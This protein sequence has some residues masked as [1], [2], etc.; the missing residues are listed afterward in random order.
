MKNGFTFLTC[1]L[2]TFCLNPL[3][4][5]AQVADTAKIRQEIDSLLTTA[6]QR[7]RANDLQVALLLAQEAGE[8]SKAYLGDKDP[9]YAASLH[10][11]ASIYK[12]LVEYSKAEELYLQAIALRAI[13]PGKEHPDY[14]ASLNNL[15]VLYIEN[16]NY[17]AA[18]PLL[19]EVKVIREKVLGNENSD[20]ATGLGNLA[21]LY[22]FKGAFIQAESLLLTAKSILGKGENKILPTYA[23]TLNNLASFYTSLGDYKKAEPLFLEAKAIQE[24]ILP[25]N[26]PDRANGLNNLGYLYLCKGDYAT[27]EPLLLE[28][29][30]IWEKG[31]GKDH[32]YYSSSLN[33][34]A[35][36]YMSNN[37][38]YGKAEPLSIEAA[39]IWEKR[40]GIENTT[41]AAHQNNLAYIYHAEGDDQKARSSFLRANKANQEILRKASTYLSEQEMLQYAELFKKQT[42]NLISFAQTNPSDSLTMA[43]Y[44]YVLFQKNALLDAAIA[45]EH[46]MLR[47]DTATQRIHA[48]W[49]TYRHRL[50]QQFVLSIEHRDTALMAILKSRVYYCEKEL[51]RRAPTFL[52]SCKLI[53]WEQ[54]R[55]HLQPGQIAI[56]FISYQYIPAKLAG[57]T[58]LY[59]ALVLRADDAAPIFVPLCAEKQLEMLIDT[60][61]KSNRAEIWESYIQ[62][63]YT[64]QSGNSS[65]YDLIWKPLE[66]YIAS[67]HPLRKEKIQIFFAPDGL[68]HRLSLQAIRNPMRKYMGEQYQLTQ[69]CSTRRLV[70]PAWYQP[71]NDSIALFGGIY[72]DKDSTRIPAPPA[73]RKV[74]GAPWED[75]PGSKVEVENIA[76][77]CQKHGFEVAMFTGYAATKEAVKSL[78]TNGNSS[79]RVLHI[80]THSFFSPDIKTEMPRTGMLSGQQQFSVDD[81]MRRAKLVLAG[82]NSARS[83]A[84]M[85]TDAEDGIL[86]AAEIETINFSNTELV[87]L[88]A[89]NT[90]LGDIAGNEGVYG[91]QR[92]FKV[93][94]SKYLIMS[95]WSVPDGATHKLMDA[96]YTNWLDKGMDIPAALRTAQ[97]YV[98]KDFSSPFY[99]ASF[100][101]IQ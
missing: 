31:M 75:L 74:R 26:H 72:Y 82:A 52:E 24:H 17:N 50:N 36:L 55:D 2:L 81:P 19:L 27:A 71:A 51:V 98:K 93:A 67:S 21:I 14:A 5:G 70:Q 56:E 92:A 34:L 86:T 69:L 90:G 79:P 54:V 48:E 88:S 15:G 44:D 37:S 61:P 78:G 57:Y 49:K 10:R 65:L 12:G 20:Y 8:L 33:N 96:F 25:A 99:W 30:S 23:S 11:Q 62:R 1:L 32:P 80:A 63:V 42:G 100:I 68:L 35:I 66:P 95:L 16:G 91:L 43:A 4:A 47:A 13:N 85:N 84:D 89:C 87:V 45:R 46:A 60:V 59:A 94:G 28:A 41:Y 18:E 76:A 9:K 40:M 6:T 39:S 97:E 58:T 29:K 64:A 53:N 73:A 22:I 3:S 101:L 77:H 7:W 38:D 83:S